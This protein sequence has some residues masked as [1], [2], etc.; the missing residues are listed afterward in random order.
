MLIFDL[1][2][3]IGSM[4][5]IYYGANFLIKYGK[6]LAISLGVSTY[7]V[8]LTVIALGTSFPELVVNLKA[9]IINESDIAFGNVIG[10]NI[11]NITLVL[12]VTAFIFRVKIS[13]QT[14]TLN[15]P[16]LLLSSL[17]FGGILYFFGGVPQ[18]IGFLFI[19][20]LLVFVWMLIRKSR[21]DNLK[22]ATDEDELLRNCY[23]SCFQ[24]AKEND[25]K[26]IAFPC[27]STGVYRF[28]N[29][30]AAKIAIN[31]SKEMMRKV[32]VREVIFVCYKYLDYHIY[33]RKLRLSSL[34]TI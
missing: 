5:L 17:V 9:S 10:S 22:A 23:R 32:D 4:L 24:L 26:T 19:F 1:F 14:V 20:L 6:I 3:F 7:I 8:G 31:T 2:Q 34:K 30:R 16:I 29:E 12:G 25:I 28:P 18:S 21:K 13:E 27:I 15:F 33:Q 11:A